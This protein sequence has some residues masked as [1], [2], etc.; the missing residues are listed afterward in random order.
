MTTARTL[1]RKL[2]KKKKRK[3]WRKCPQCG[4]ECEVQIKDSF[5]LPA[6]GV[7]AD[8][9]PRLVASCEKCKVHWELLWFGRKSLRRKKEPYEE[10]RSGGGIGIR[11]PQTGGD[12]SATAGGLAPPVASG[13]EGVL[14]RKG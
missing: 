7:H 12:Q 9:D 5:Q 2:Q 1:R 6:D 13:W 8:G 3:Q 10:T 14:W 11:I 4:D